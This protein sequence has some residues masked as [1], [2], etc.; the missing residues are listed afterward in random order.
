M[1]LSFIIHEPK[2]YTPKATVPRP[3]Y[4]LTHSLNDH[5]VEYQ[6]LIPMGW[7]MPFHHIELTDLCLSYE[8]LLA[9]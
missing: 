9:L 8:T 3:A 5:E 1:Y 4:T 7:C 6:K 2:Y